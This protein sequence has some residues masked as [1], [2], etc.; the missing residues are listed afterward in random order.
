[1]VTILPAGTADPEPA[2]DPERAESR[3]SAALESPPPGGTQP[4]SV[5]APLY[6]HTTLSALGLPAGTV[7]SHPVVDPERAEQRAREATRFAAEKVAQVQHR[8]REATDSTSQAAQ[9]A[10]DSSRQAAGG[11]SCC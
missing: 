3:A 5:C 1:M 2:A 10:M 8:A 6:L 11:L 7:D 4:A 9:Q